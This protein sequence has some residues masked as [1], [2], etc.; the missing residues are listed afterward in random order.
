MFRPRQH[1]VKKIFKL[2]REAPVFGEK[3]RAYLVRADL[4]K[5]KWFCDH[6]RASVDSQQPGV[7]HLILTPRTT[8][9]IRVLLEEEGL[10]GLVTVWELNPGFLV[11]DDDLLSMELPEVFAECF[12]HGDQVRSNSDA[13]SRSKSSVTK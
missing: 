13:T 1:G 11:L 8:H 2:S 9:A 10:F 3:Q 4:A 7:Y 12:V 6:A 5:V